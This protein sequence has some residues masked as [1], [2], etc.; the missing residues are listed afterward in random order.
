M[1]KDA[2]DLYREAT[3]LDGH[4]TC[5]WVCA[6]NLSCFI[7]D[8]K[9]AL[10]ADHKLMEVSRSGDLSMVDVHN[11]LKEWVRAR[12]QGERNSAKMTAKRLYV[13]IS[14]PA[15]AICREYES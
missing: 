5:A 10:S 11:I 1:F 15:L 13:R 3:D 6:F 4:S 7:K 9:G 14:E 2:R 12:S 8:E